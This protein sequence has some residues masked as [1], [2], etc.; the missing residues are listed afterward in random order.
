MVIETQNF[1]HLEFGQV[2]KILASSELNIHS[3]VEVLTAASSWL[4]H[5]SE[6]RR[7]YAKELL[8]KVRLTLLS[9]HALKYILDSKTLLTEVQ[10]CVKILKE[11]Y[12][13]Q[14]KQTTNNR[15]TTR[16]CSQNMFSFLLCGGFD[17]LSMNAV[18]TVNQ[19][20]GSNLNKTKVLSPMTIK[21]RNF[22][23]V[24]LKG[25]VYIFG[26]FDSNGDVLMPVEKYSPSNNTWN[27]IT[28]MV[29]NCGHFCTCAFMDRIY[30]VGGVCYQTYKAT[31]SCLQ[32]DTKNKSWEE[33]AKMN[34]ARKF[35]ACVVFQ[36]NVVVSGG[37]NI[38]N[39]DLNSVE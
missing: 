11:V 23:A 29:D 34:E 36:G 10:E 35:A 26:G 2:L 21:R 7:T 39:N 4:K 28:D 30:I 15:F 20:Y 18:K 13:N 16:Y 31:D 17:T 25:E 5:N 19:V 24:C 6:E 14:L 9:E 37:K 22:E 12:K 32:F 33:I 27:L 38:N 1:L 3:E 8:L